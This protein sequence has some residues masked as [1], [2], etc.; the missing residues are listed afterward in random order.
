MA[1]YD[2]TNP[3]PQCEGPKLSIPEALK[4]QAFNAYRDAVEAKGR[5][6]AGGTSCPNCGYCPHCGRSNN[7]FPS[8]PNQPFPGQV[9]CSTTGPK[10]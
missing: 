10:C 9:W 1:I 6:L 2:E 4:E 8:Y 3:A 7:S 5:G